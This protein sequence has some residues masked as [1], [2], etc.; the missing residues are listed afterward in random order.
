MTAALSILRDLLYSPSF[1]AF[2]ACV[3]FMYA[4][5]HITRPGSPLG[6]MSAGMAKGIGQHAKTHALL[7]L[8]A[9]MLAAS[10]TADAV[11]DNFGGLNRADW[12]AMGWWQLTALLGKS[13]KPA[14][15]AISALLVKP[16][17]VSADGSGTAPP[18]P[19]TPKQL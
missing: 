8:L 14:A 1:L 16:P 4:Y 17:V 10:A 13:L 5:R 11:A 19:I 3:A 15:V 2:L 9:F 7:Y 12:E 6:E 18:F